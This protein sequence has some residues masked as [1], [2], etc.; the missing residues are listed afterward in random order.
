[1]NNMTEK[2]TNPMDELFKTHKLQF[3]SEEHFNKA[4]SLKPNCVDIGYS[5]MIFIFET[6]EERIDFKTKIAELIRSEEH[7][8]K[9]NKYRGLRTDNNEWVYGQYI[10][11]I[12]GIRINHCIIVDNDEDTRGLLEA[13]QIKYYVS[14]E[15]I[16]QFTGRMDINSNE[17]YVD[18]GIEVRS[19]HDSNAFDIVW[20]NEK[21][22][23]ITQIITS[24]DILHPI[25]MPSDSDENPTY[26][27]IVGNIHENTE[28]KEETP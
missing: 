14:P 4:L 2:T 5:D 17:M 9:P 10:K 20:N 3:D 28:L 6:L 26:W 1:M 24:S 22:E 21:Q 25:N 18:D 27:E 11:L 12:E 13:Q 23:A 15:T 16:G 8:M 19:L 7:K